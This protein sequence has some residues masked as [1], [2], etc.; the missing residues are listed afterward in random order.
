MRNKKE[1][2]NEYERLNGM[3]N[4]RARVDRVSR[5]TVRSLYIRGGGVGGGVG[6]GGGG[7]F[8]LYKIWVYFKAI[9]WESIIL[10]LPSHLQSLP[11]CNTFARPL[12]S[13]RSPH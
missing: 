13:I 5:V 3:M 11:D 6:G 2:N 12:R 8:S 4:P 7:G 9:Y 1:H 10:L